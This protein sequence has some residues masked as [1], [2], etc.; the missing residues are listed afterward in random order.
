M[1]G[2]INIGLSG[3]LGHQAALNTTGNNISNANTDG[4]SRQR[5]DFESSP[6]MRTGAGTIGTG[7]NIS[8]IERITNEFVTQQVRTDTSLSSEQEALNTE[9]SRLDN[10]L[11]GESTGLNSAL[12]NFFSSLQSA[13]EDPSALPQRKLVLSEANELASRFQ[14][15]QTELRQQRDSVTGQMANAAKDVNSLIASVADLNTKISETPG[16][17]QGEMPNNLL[18]QRDEKLRELSE[19]VKINVS[20][21]DG[22][23]VNVS[24]TGGQALVVGGRAASLDTVES[25]SDPNQLDFQLRTGNRVAR[26]TEQIVGGTMGGLRTFQEQALEPA[27]DELGRVAIAVSEQVNHQ[28][29]IGM[30]LEGDLGGNL[31]TDINSEAVR[32]SRVTA[33]SGNAPPQDATIGVE[34]T[35]SNQLDGRSYQLRFGGNNGN[36]YELIDRTSGEVVSQ[37]SLPSP[38]PAEIAQDGFNVQIEEGT[39]Q[40]GDRF[41]IQP[42]KNAAANIGVEIEREQDLALASPIKAEA[43]SGNAGNGVIN[44]GTM[45]NVDNPLTNQRL[46]SFSQQGELNPPLMIRFSDTENYEILDASDPNN[47]QS[48]VPPQ[49][50]SFEPGRPNEIF[51]EDPTDPNY[52]GF[53][54]AINGNPEANDTFLINYNGDGTSDNRNAQL[55]GGLGTKDTMNNGNQNFSEAY[56]GL[57]ETVGVQSRQSNLDLEAGK[58]L[59]EQS[60]NQE[61]S[62][63][64]VNLDEEAGRLIQYQNAY[65]ANA[66]VMSVA[67]ELFNTLLGTFQ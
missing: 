15:L 30:D 25:Q 60:T 6:G 54:F 47:P 29:A 59:L 66:R 40:Q 52:R 41:L 27:F 55:L 44:Q 37:G 50:G 18:D 4:Y 65:S 31:F 12:N 24:L 58:A 45:L 42:T 8:N 9:L 56:G 19:L 62:I 64:G 46:D 26:V 33:D 51:T 53:Q 3:I 61:Q 32:L 21:A 63:S 23:Q 34:I 38:L 67:Q 13:A 20:Q 17:A 48:F 28:H 11:G 14:S 7:V 49:T 22:Q 2:L 57:V 1:A 39:F 10:L 16:L 5:V 43:D 36:N 35:D